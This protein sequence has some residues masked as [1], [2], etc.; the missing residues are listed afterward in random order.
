[1][2]PG[3]RS[4]RIVA[5]RVSEVHQGCAAISP[6]RRGA[7]PRKRR[8]TRFSITVGVGGAPEHVGCVAVSAMERQP[9]DLAT[10]ASCDLSLSGFGGCA[11]LW[12][13]RDVTS[14]LPHDRAERHMTRQAGPNDASEWEFAAEFQKCACDVF[15]ATVRGA[16][17]AKIQR[18]RRQGPPSWRPACEVSAAVAR[19]SPRS[20]SSH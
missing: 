1:M 4:G 14:A 12:P 19:C 17:M 15:T 2:V 13:Q 11:E 20:S 16:T 7:I 5:D 6:R 18:A 9:S 3:G 8:P 10:A